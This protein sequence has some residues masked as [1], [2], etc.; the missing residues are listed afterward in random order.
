A[1]APRAIHQ[2]D[3]AV[4]PQAKPRGGISDGYRRAFRGSRHLQQQL[5]LLRMQPGMERGRLAEMQEAAQLIAEISQG[6]EERVGCGCC[7]QVHIYIVTRYK[8]ECK[9]SPACI[10]R[11]YSN[12]ENPPAL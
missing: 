6:S 10:R 3:R 12:R 5:V 2:F 8:Y 9:S 11:T 4:M 1:H 7:L